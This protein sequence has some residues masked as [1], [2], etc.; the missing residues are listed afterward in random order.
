MKT[1]YDMKHQ[2]NIRI[3]TLSALLVLG[4]GAT[5][6]QGPDR[7]AFF[8]TLD[9]DGNGSLTR[10]ELEAHAEARFASAD[11]DGD[12][13]LTADELRAAQQA[14]REDHGKRMLERLDSDGDGKLDAAE[15][16]KGKK[17][18]SDQR[19]G[20]MIERLD[21][22]NDARLSRAELLSRHDPARVFGRLDANAN[23]AVTAEEF[24]QGHAKGKGH[25][26][27]HQAD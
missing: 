1:E 7:A 12:G 25:G 6:A 21:T 14:H 16:A 9:A 18:K 22:D 8:A 13:F 27:R 19:A 11:A 24:A 20:R 2:A 10:A 5:L 26:R 4:A 23:G 15:L 3:A 17:G